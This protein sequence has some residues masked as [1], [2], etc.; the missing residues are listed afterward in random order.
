[1]LLLSDQAVPVSAQSDSF[2][3]MQYADQHRIHAI[4]LW[5]DKDKQIFR[6]QLYDP[7]FPSSVSVSGMHTFEAATFDMRT[8][9]G[10]VS[11]GSL[12]S[13]MDHTWEYAASFKAT[14]RR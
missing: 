3:L 6:G 9:S 5:F 1:V 2:G 12:Q 7:G 14:I 8:I 4:G 11:T 10:K 13:F